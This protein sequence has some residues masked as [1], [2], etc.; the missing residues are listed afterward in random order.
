MK[1][2]TKILALLTLV[3]MFTLTKSRAQEIGVTLQLSRPPQYEQNET[4]HPPRPTPNNMWVAEEWAF[5]YGKW[6]YVPGRWAIPPSP[7]TY[8][9]RGKW[10]RTNNGTYV[11]SKGHWRGYQ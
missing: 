11:W 10:R 5:R 6:V 9:E 1:K 7:G 4:V 2:I 3:L 8:W